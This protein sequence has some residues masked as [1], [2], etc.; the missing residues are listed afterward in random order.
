MPHSSGHSLVDETEFGL[1]AAEFIVVAKRQHQIK[2]TKL[3]FL[4]NLSGDSGGSSA[5][6]GKNVRE[7]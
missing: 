6:H 1:V 3:I 7:K 2:S 4:I 5:D